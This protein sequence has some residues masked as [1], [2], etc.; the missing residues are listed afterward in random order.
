MRSSNPVLT[1]RDTFD[2]ARLEE[3]YATPMPMTLDDVVVRTAGLL[4]VLGATG[5]VAWVLELYALA[6]PALIVGLVLAF[7]CAFKAQPSPALVVAYA[8]VEGVFIGALSRVFEDAYPGIVLQAVGGTAL[9]FGGVL[10]AYKSGRLRAT[11]R[12]RRVIVSAMIGIFALYTINFVAYL[13]GG[14]L[15][16]IRDSTPLGILFSVAV[17]TVAAL[18]FVL[19]F[20]LVDEA[21]RHGAPE[22]FAWKA[23]FGLVVGLVWLYIEILRLLAKLRD[24]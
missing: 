18:S 6:I 1:R 14:S 17:V 23:A 21:I 13:F 15:P 12:F 4:G 10:V 20:E 3:M 2:A 24:R 9:C 19:D 22:R 8:A 5:A 16:V 7:V 11:P